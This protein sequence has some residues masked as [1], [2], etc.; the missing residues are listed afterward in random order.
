MV[1]CLGAVD[2]IGAGVGLGCGADIGFTEVGVAEIDVGKDCVV[3]AFACC[4]GVAPNTA[5]SNVLGFLI[6]G[7]LVPSKLDIKISYA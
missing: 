1:S 6:C 7:G 4:V 3:G 5:L 2:C